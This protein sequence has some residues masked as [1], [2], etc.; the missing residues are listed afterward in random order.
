MIEDG[1]SQGKYVESVDNT[2]QDLKHFQHFLYRHFYKTKYYD[3]MHPISNQ[4]AR[5]FAIAKTH[6]FNKIEDIN[7]QDLKLRP[8]IYQTGTYIILPK[9]LQTT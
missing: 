1:I 6:K 2:H 4:P 9:L 7:I 5:F 3:K 8:I